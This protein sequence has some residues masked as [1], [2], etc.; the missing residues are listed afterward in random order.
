MEIVLNENEIAKRETIDLSKTFVNM[1]YGR[2]IIHY[3]LV[4]MVV[5]RSEQVILEQVNLEL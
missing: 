3:L 4:M 1:F 2:T 5:Y